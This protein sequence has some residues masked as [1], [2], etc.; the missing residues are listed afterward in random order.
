MAWCGRRPVEWLLENQAV[1]ARWCL[2]HATHASD[3]ELAQ[4]C[5]RGAVVG[6]CPI[7]E[8]SLGDGIF[9]AARVSRSAGPHRHRQ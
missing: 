7:T 8:A 4:I 6:L 3:A 2:V 9:P 5:A 1:D